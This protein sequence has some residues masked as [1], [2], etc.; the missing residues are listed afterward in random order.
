MERQST[1]EGDD[2]VAKK[3]KETPIGHAGL[4]WQVRRLYAIVHRERAAHPRT[5]VWK[6]LEEIAGEIHKIQQDWFRR[7]S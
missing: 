5:K 6:D 3:E 1:R 2:V 7:K 4:Y